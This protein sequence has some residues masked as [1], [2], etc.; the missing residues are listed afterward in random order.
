MVKKKM[1]KVIQMLSPENYIRKKVRNLPVYECLVNTE[2]KEQGVAHIV[3][4]RNHTNGN[5]T[6][7]MYLVDLFC[8]GIKNT[9]YL[10]NIPESEY[11]ST[12]ESMEHIVFE[13]INYTLA[14][15]IV[16]AGLEYAEEYG[17][18]PHKDFTSITRF[19]LEEDTE[20]IELI[21]IECGKDG[22]P[23]YVNG[24]Y[25]DQ[26]KINQI[27]AQLDRTAGPG[28]FDFEIVDDED[29]FDDF[30]DEFER[31][32]FE[33]QR[34]LFHKLNAKRDDLNDDEDEQLRRL[35]EHV[36]DSIVS[37]EM[38]DQYAEEYLNDFDF[39]VTDDIFTEEMLGL[40]NHELSTETCELFSEIYDAANENPEAAKLLLNDFRSKTPENPAACFLE[41]I[42]LRTEGSSEYEEIAQKYY[43]RF[44]EY[45]LLK[46]LMTTFLFVNISNEEEVET[47]EAFTMQSLFPGRTWIHHIEAFNY[48]T[49]LLLGLTRIG[50]IDRIQ[51]LY[52]AYN[53]LEL[54]DE[55]F[56]I[57]EEYIFIVKSAIVEQIFLIEE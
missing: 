45:P 30:D 50:D 41:L 9:Q 46:I 12:K 1:G 21:D 10:F 3:V 42:I 32:T 48:L 23:F 43:S 22:K 16:F 20:D 54:T 33:E 26:A 37:P 28:N 55:E 6:A 17:F 8:L 38:V 36:I 29:E 4:A 18:K 39:E 25:E 44:P 49:T 11:R 34:N 40:A 14:H 7:C 27:I 31:M 35:T 19:M 52:E 2:W 53:N 24:P 5:I 13:P 51:G 15:N 47:V 57:L 56:D